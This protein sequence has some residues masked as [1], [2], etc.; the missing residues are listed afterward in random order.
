MLVGIFL[1]S[2]VVRSPC[3]SR[4]VNWLWWW[5]DGFCFWPILQLLLSKRWIQMASSCSWWRPDQDLDLAP[6]M[7]VPLLKVSFQVGSRSKTATLSATEAS[8]NH[9]DLA[10]L[11]V[12][13]ASSCTVGAEEEWVKKIIPFV[14][15]SRFAGFICK[16]FFCFVTC[17]LHAYTYMYF[18]LG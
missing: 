14:L 17:L 7:K 18:R 9:T 10:R 6:A 8:E 5:R 4:N 3:Q 16:S 1:Q 12:F 13:E 2:F 11:N 15:S